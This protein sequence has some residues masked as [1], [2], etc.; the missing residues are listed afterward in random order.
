MGDNIFVVASGGLYRVDN[1]STSPKATL[2]VHGTFDGTA[3][4]PDG[5][6]IYVP[7]GQSI[8]GFDRSG[9]QVL[10]VDVCCHNPDGLVVAP[11]GASIGG[12]DVSGDI[13]AND[14]DGTMLRLDSKHGYR[15][16]VVASGGLRGDFMTLGLDGCL[17]A[18]QGNVVVRMEPC[19][20]IPTG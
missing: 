10:K 9:Q 20:S 12:V 18:S 11:S 2:L 16:N 14:N 7:S 13:F 8:V 1:L 19:L 6:R 5:S 4:S 17:Y 15:V 3:V